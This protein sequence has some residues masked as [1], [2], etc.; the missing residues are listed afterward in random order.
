MIRENGS[1]SYTLTAVYR[2]SQSQKQPNTFLITHFQ[3]NG[4]VISLHS[5]Q[6]PGH[7]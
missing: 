5:V 1:I 2:V 6:L 4:T 3:V 7:Q